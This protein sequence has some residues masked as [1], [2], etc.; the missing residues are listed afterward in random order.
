MSYPEPYAVY[1]PPAAG[2]VAPPASRTAA[3]LL[4]AVC[5]LLLTPVGIGLTAFGGYRQ[6]QVMARFA[7]GADGLA[8]TLV[9]VGALVLFGVAA[10]GA[11]S[12][13]GPAF[14]G[15]VWGIVPGV[16]GMVSTRSGYHLLDLLPRGDLNTGLLTWMFSGALLGVGF[17][18]VSA[19][20]VGRLA[21]RRR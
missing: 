16:V 20:L 15:L 6:A 3:R 9:V 8:I 18:L 5:G 2:M 10:L 7:A 1:P 14:G 4:S 21:R 12:G 13:T 19:G 17:V 11:F